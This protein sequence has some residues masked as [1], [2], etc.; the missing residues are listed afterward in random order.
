VSIVPPVIYF[1]FSA[2]K[3]RSVSIAGH[4]TSFTLEDSFWAL[5]KHYANYHHI[6]VASVILKLDTM[7][8][9]KNQVGLSCILRQFIINDVLLNPTHYHGLAI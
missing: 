4:K 5:L 7:R 6:S 9:D 3:K 1:N 2:P 8:G